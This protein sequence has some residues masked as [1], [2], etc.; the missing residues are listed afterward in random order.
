MTFTR[1]TIRWLAA[2]ILVVCGTFCPSAPLLKHGTILDGERFR[3]YEKAF[4]Q[5]VK[6]KML[7]AP[8]GRPMTFLDEF[9]AP[10]LGLG[11][12]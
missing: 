7:P 4:R 9:A 10:L 8:D 1:T 6:G 3:A 2:T 12:I 5:V 11:G